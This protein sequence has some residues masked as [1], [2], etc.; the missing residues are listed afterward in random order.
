MKKYHYRK[1]L[2]YYNNRYACYCV[3]NNNTQGICIF[4]DFSERII[5]SVVTYKSGFRNGINI[6]FE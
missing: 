4:S 6:E 5:Y 2:Q 3:D 1:T